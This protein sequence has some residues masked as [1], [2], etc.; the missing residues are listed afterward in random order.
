[1]PFNSKRQG[2]AQTLLPKGVYRMVIEAVDTKPG[3]SGHDY[4]NFRL[5]P[6]VNGQKHGQ[7][8]WDK[9]SL[10]PEARFRIENFSDALGIPDTDEDVDEKDLVGKSFWASVSTREYNGT[11]SNEIKQY[12]TPE[13]AERLLEKQ[14][15]EGGFDNPITVPSRSTRP[16]S[17]QAV[18]ASAKAKGKKSAVAEL[19]DEDAVF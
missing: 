9:I 15:E 17:E 6:I 4:F 14:A 5:R 12:L 11:Y 18:S 13:T 8:I 3:P 10:S 19:D 2:G 16:V 7:A 1:M